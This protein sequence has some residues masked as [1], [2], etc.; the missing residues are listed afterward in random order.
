MKCSSLFGC[1]AESRGDGRSEAI[2]VWSYDVVSIEELATLKFGEAWLEK[3]AVDLPEG[4]C[5]LDMD[6]QKCEMHSAKLIFHFFVLIGLLSV[7]DN[8]TIDVTNQACA[9]FKWCQQFWSYGSILETSFAL[10][11]LVNTH[12]RYSTSSTIVVGGGSRTQTKCFFFPLRTYTLA[13]GSFSPSIDFSW[14]IESA[15]NEIWNLSWI[16]QLM[17]D[18]VDQ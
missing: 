13:N 8:Q 17:P 2:C 12:V 15:T 9:N 18:Q 3:R 1:H 16:S 10:P 7:R 4:Q 11:Y 5:G 14:E 6:C